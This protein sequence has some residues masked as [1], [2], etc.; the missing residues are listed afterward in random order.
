MDYL[1][2]IIASLLLAVYFSINKVYQKQ[3]GTSLRT[4]SAFNSL[5][6]LFAAIIFFCVNGFKINITWYSLIM[7]T[8]YSSLI[9][10][11]TVLG[12]RLLKEGSMALYTLFLMTG[13]M[14]L[15]YVFGLIFLN[16]P[17][18]W[19]K[20]I[21]L[22]VIMSGV[23]LSNLKGKSSTNTLVLILC[24]IVFILNGFVSI[25]SKIHQSVNS[26][27]I[28]NT[29]EFVVLTGFVKFVVAGFLFLISKKDD[30][31]I[32]EKRPNAVIFII[33]L[34][35]ASAVVQGVSSSLQLISAIKLPA[36]VLY[37]FITGGTIIF[38]SIAGVIFFKDKLSKQLIISIALC[39]IG[40]LLFL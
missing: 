23:V 6:G 32:S 14:L 9:M 10:V 24:A 5:I 35:L 40:T 2:I 13:G 19:L 34:T 37:P 1:I 18:S 39:F 12:F 21:G 22:V 17:F 8:I 36:S 16:E 28:V 26:F 15:P 33:L 30:S 25:T 27:P 4:A 38:S 20:T 7:A 11:Y 31:E 29:N 3:N